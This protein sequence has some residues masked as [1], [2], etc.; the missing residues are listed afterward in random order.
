[1]NLLR[2]GEM[3]KLNK[4]SVQTLHYYEK[5]GLLKPQVVDTESGYRY[6]HVRQCATLDLIGYMKLLGMSLTQIKQLF[7]KN[8][9][10]L[11]RENIASQLNW[12]EEQKE[13]LQQME[14]GV[15]RFQFSLKEFEE[16]SQS[17]EVELLTFPERKIF[18]YDGKQDIY[19]GS[20][21]T[22]EYIIRELKDQAR[23]K[24]LP[25]IYFCNVGSVIRQDNIQS[26][27][28][29]SSEIFVFVD[30]EFPNA[31]EVKV[32]P[33][34][35]YVCLSFRGEDG[36]ANELD[37]AKILL[38]YVD[39][40][41][42]SISGDYLCEVVAELPVYDTEARGMFIRIQVPVINA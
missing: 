21:E 26:R 17:R 9:V 13:K 35:T 5:I 2:I 37:Y 18:C 8:D 31:P 34:G 4:I 12:I 6:Y 36:F 28:F 11:I 14:R 27:N 33:A 32:V 38:D 42:Y 16:T 29:F 7:E 22:Y 19:Q 20:I 41:G 1:M 15:R 25:M 10:S 3:A 23:L 30:D 24:H 39:K 40:H